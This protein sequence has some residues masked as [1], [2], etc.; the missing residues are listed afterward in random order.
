MSTRSGL[1]LILAAL[2]GGRLTAQ[3]SSQDRHA[4]RSPTTGGEATRTV[5]M[6]HSHEFGRHAKGVE[7]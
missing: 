6:D 2:C 4:M 7:S 1:A 3:T 5:T